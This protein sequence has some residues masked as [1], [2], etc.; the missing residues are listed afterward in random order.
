MDM[1]EIDEEEIKEKFRHLIH[2]MEEYAN[3]GLAIV[4]E[5]FES[6]RYFF[7]EPFAF[8]SLLKEVA[9]GKYH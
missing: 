2:I 6:D 1:E 7:Q 8:M 5:W 9:D 4:E 3:A